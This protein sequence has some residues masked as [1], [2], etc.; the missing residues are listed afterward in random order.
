MNK[1]I[2]FVTTNKTK[3]ED[4]KNS[5]KHLDITLEH[6]ESELFEPQSTEPKSIISSKL[7]QAIEKFP[8]KM[9]VVDDRSLFI[10]SLKGFPGPSLKLTMKTIGA[11]GLLNLMKSKKDRKMIFITAIGFY[12]GKE[13]HYFYHHEYGSMLKKKKGNNL[14]G[15]TEILH[16][17]AHDKKPGKSLAEYTDE[18]WDNHVNYVNITEKLVKK[19][20][21]ALGGIK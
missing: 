9:L 12:D 15:W 16:I 7:K 10:P 3:F 21:E 1:K 6:L 14:R 4:Y 8:G 2:Y 19:V 11:E 20:R 13:E 18:E 17:Y 5:F